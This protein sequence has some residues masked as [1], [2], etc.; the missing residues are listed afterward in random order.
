MRSLV[1]LVTEGPRGEIIRGEDAYCT[2]W[3]ASGARRRTLQRQG[4]AL[5]LRRGID[6]SL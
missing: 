2:G 6:T 3:G 5:R 1:E 4:R